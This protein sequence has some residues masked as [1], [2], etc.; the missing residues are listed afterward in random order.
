MRREALKQDWYQ[1]QGV[2]GYWPAQSDGNDL[3]IYDPGSLAAGEPVELT[4]F[5][6]P[7]QEREDNLSLADYF[8]PT[9]FGSHGCGCFPGG[10]GWKMCHRAF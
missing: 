8:S 6:F 7:R 1:P 3:V 4:R 2:Y 9:R 10:D 5:N